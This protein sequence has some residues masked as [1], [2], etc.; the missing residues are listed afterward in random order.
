MCVNAGMLR[1]FLL[2]IPASTFVSVLLERQ[3]PF[4][5]VTRSAR[6]QQEK[7]KKKQQQQQK[8]R[9]FRLAIWFFETKKLLLDSIHDRITAK[10]DFPLFSTGVTLVQGVLYFRQLIRRSVETLATIA[11]ST[12]IC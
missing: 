6:G 1:S 12:Q 11:T 3:G 7:A 5:I 4:D 8:T 10:V 9:Y 2:L